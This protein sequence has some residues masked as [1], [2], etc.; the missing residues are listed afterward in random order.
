MLSRLLRL[1]VV[2]LCVAIA[3]APP[4][5][6]APA[7]FK[8]V[9]L[10]ADAA[11]HPDAQT[12]WWYFT[13]HL[14]D[15]AGRRFGFEFTTFK[16]SGFGPQGAAEGSRAYKLDFAI[17]DE[18]SRRFYSQI[19]YLRD[20]PG[21]TI[22]RADTLRTRL[23]GGTVTE[24]MTTLAGPGLRYALH[25]SM[26]GAALDLVVQT[27]RRPLLQGGD[28]VERFGAAGFSYYYSLTNM[29]SSGSL[30]LNGQRYTVT[31]TTWMDHQWG[32]WQWS[33]S[34]G[35]DWM[36]IQLANGTS[37]TLYN[38]VSGH[39]T[40]LKYVGTSFPDG[41]QRFSKTATMAPLGPTWTS[42]V[43]HTRY[44]Q[45][46]HVV[47]P[48]LGL[49]ATVLPTIAQQEMVDPFNLAPTYWE[50]SCT[51]VGTLHGAPISGNAYTE[52]VGYAQRSALGV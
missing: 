14:R 1:T 4:A 13:G 20:A 22:M 43:T 44:P 42:P 46:W 34:T 27:T 12:E 35:W 23:A 17:T 25:G 3:A 7:R 49:D 38:F 37:I 51:L 8:P 29:S 47:V 15:A 41:S 18:G 10:P 26:R 31:G 50:G 11:M 32:T 5:G 45:G 24:N 16:L 52:L 19:N 36:G 6:A 30:R 48:S 40:G 28:G 33:T 21:R 9:R 2:L 39:G